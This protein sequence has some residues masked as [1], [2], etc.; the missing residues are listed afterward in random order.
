[1]TILEF[2]RRHSISTPTY[3]KLR[4]DG[5]G[6]AEMRRGALV[7]ITREAAAKWRED[8]SNP[9]GDEAAAVARSAAALRIRSLHAAKG[10]VAS[11]RARLEVAG[12]GVSRF[13]HGQSSTKIPGGWHPQ[14]SED[15]WTA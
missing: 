4:T 8:R 5:L 12:G 2:C 9:V 11:P 15:L 3:Y 13:D 6:P 10:A 7:R 1:M 14:G